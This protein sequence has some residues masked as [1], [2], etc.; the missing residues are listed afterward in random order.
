MMINNLKNN[1]KINVAFLIFN[2]IEAMDLNGPLDVFIKANYFDDKYN[3]YTISETKEE[4]FSEGETLTMIAKYTFKDAPNSDIL[5]LPG[6]SPEELKKNTLKEENILNWIKEQHSQTTITM[7]I[8]TGALLLSKCG[9]L[10]NKK[11]TTHYLVFEDL[12]KYENI[13]VVEDV[14]FIHDG[15]VITTAA[16]ISGIDSTLY[17]IKL[18][19]GE[20]VMNNI[21]KVLHHEYRE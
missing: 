16:I 15:K 18:I 5:I 19:S 10:D 1:K 20:E 9:I 7:A 11:A 8:C 4:L 21:C 2:Q 6:A 17:L 3:V 14:R 13:D 12:K